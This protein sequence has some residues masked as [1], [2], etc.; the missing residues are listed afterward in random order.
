VVQVWGQNSFF[1]TGT[2]APS[3][4]NPWPVARP[5]SLCMET[6]RM[7]ACSARHTLL[8][9]TLGLV[10]ACGDNT[11]GALGSG[12]TDSRHHLQ[13]LSQWYCA[14]AAAVDAT[15]DDG[16]HNAVEPKLAENPPVIV[17]IAAAAGIIGS[18]SLALDENGNLYSWGVAQATGHG[19]MKPV[20]S[21]RQ[22]DT[23]P[24][25]QSAAKG[26]P[27]ERVQAEAEARTFYYTRGV[28]AVA[29][30]ACGSGFT[31]CVLQDTGE[32][33]C[34]GIWQHG[35]LGRP[36]PIIQTTTG[37]RRLFRSSAGGGDGKKT[38][39][40]YQ[41]RPLLVPG[42]SN[43]ASVACGDAHTLCRTR[44]GYLLAWGQNS[45]GQ[46]G[47]GVSRSGFLRDNHRPTYVAPF[48]PPLE[49]KN[50]DPGDADPTA[51][52]M[53]QHSGRKVTVVACGTFH[54]AVVEEGGAVWTWGA[55]GHPCLGH[56]DAPLIGPWAKKIQVIFA[57]ATN[58][59]KLMIP[60]ELV[61]WVSTWSVPRC[62]DSLANRRR[63]APLGVVLKST[64]IVQVSCGDMHSAFLS[65]TGRIFFCGDG[66]VVPPIVT[67][68]H[69]QQQGEEE[70]EEGEPGLESDGDSATNGTTG[71]VKKERAPAKAKKGPGGGGA[72]LGDGDGS[73]PV[74]V[75][76]EPPKGSKGGAEGK[77]GDG[78]EGEEEEEP[79]LPENLSMIHIP[80][81]PSSSWLPRLASRRTLL[82]AS[83][84]THMFALQDDDMVASSISKR[85]LLSLQSETEQVQFAEDIG[86]RVVDVPGSAD[87]GIELDDDEGD[88]T[89]MSVGGG[90]SSAARSDRSLFEQRGCADCMLI[91]S[92]KIL[93]AHRAVLAARSPVLRDKLV[94]EAPGG[95]DYNQPTQIL[96]P[97]LLHGTARVLLQYLYTDNLP[98]RIV[99]NPSM[100][101]NLARAATQLKIPRLQIMCHQLL[102]LHTSSGGRGDESDE[103]ATSRTAGIG[104][105]VVPA[106][107]ARDF[108]GLVGDPQYADIRFITQ[109]R[110]LFA[111]RAVLEARSVYFRSMFRSGMMES[112]VV[113]GKPTDIVVPDR[114][115]C[116]LRMMI[117]I[118][119]DILPEGSDEALLEDLVTADRYQIMDMRC[120][121]ENM[122]VP[123]KDNWR[124]LLQV[125]ESIH[126]SRLK[127][128]TVGFLRNH[129]GE[130]YL[131]GSTEDIEQFPGVME[132][133]LRMRQVAFP[134][135]PSK[136]LI[137]KITTNVKMEEEN[138]K[139]DFP[140]VGLVI[141]AVIGFVF[142][143]VVKVTSLGPLIPWLNGGMFIAVLFYAYKRVL[144]M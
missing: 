67:S 46:L 47:T 88:C 95:D 71:G 41:L 37:K 27:L 34:W 39:A 69:E 44:E 14:P 91:S 103:G 85:I 89:D 130:A 90:D 40:R 129:L 81:C 35:R 75:K 10:Y 21:P 19:V 142:T 11:E 25:P 83:G 97:E 6:V 48:C 136:L 38:Y 49:R 80:R 121:C 70:E 137:E 22:I 60:Y 100:L 13:V 76:E 61:P 52:S 120:L 96:L 20:L 18:H 73:P 128:E 102:R 72:G 51:S 138:N 65:A 113:N 16:H 101:R 133:I 5:L 26:D 141:I 53:S 23:F 68:P 124:E 1:A 134:T 98:K 86:A 143:F 110:T 82:I 63:D 33:C 111:H 56:D 7:V 24:V 87:V 12:D 77:G 118:Y 135:P 117:F 116:L 32:V 17:K 36:V 42:I 54:S 144:S 109:G 140:W 106:T 122:L 29:D 108:G 59:T 43:A 105:E 119:T 115:V 139:V 93:L 31:A 126:S 78:E 57:A 104:V 99:G 79:P 94:E 123:T 50:R 2:R 114:F 30:V 28:R 125:A 132:D 55:R 8:L 66:P 112:F 127:S 107:L 9:T 74:K 131:S 92:G 15:T 45:C 3:V 64:R 62:L 4:G 84:G 58:T